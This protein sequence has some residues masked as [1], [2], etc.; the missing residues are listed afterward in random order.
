MQKMAEVAPNAYNF[1]LKTAAEV[2]ASPF[3]EE[4]VAEL[5]TSMEKAAGLNPGGIPAQIGKNLLT[6][7]P[8]MIIGGVAATLAGDMVDSIRRGLTKTHNYKKMLKAN[9]DLD[10]SDPSVKANFETLHRFNPEYSADPNVAG[11]YVRHAKQFPSDIGMVHGL[12][13]SRKAIRDSRALRPMSVP[14]EH[15]VDEDLRQME[16]NKGRAQITSSEAQAAANRAQRMAQLEQTKKLRFERGLGYP[17]LEPERQPYVLPN[18]HNQKR[19]RDR[20]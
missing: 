11:G 20:R 8:V 7:A 16:L 6:Y 10:G 18:R 2:R 17:S 4:I 5:N 19:D 13:S 3:R 9:D 12:V 14:M 1:I 15:P